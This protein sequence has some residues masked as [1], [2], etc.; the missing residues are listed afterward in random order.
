MV[1][2]RRLTKFPSTV[3]SKATVSIVSTSRANVKDILALVGG[4]ILSEEVES[5]GAAL[6]AVDRCGMNKAYLQGNLYR[7]PE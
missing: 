1:V 4:A 7:S 3:E 2:G 5:L 6:I